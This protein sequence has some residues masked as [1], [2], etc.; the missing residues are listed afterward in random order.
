MIY[1]PDSKRGLEV[2]VDA[3]FAGGWNPEEAGDADN[4]Y[5][6]T[7]FI[8][9]YAGCPIYWQSK[10]QTEIALS[11]AEAEYI[12]MSQ[13]LRETI[14]LAMLMREM[15]ESFRCTYHNPGSSSKCGKTISLV[16]QCSNVFRS[17]L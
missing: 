9:Y 14:P 8:I 16:L 11:T 12:S 1:A 2:W 3:D 5:S 15:N 13:A 6:R 10:L 4:V 7:G 17:I